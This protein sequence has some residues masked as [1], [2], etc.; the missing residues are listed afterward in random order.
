MVLLTRRL[1]RTA[2]PLAVAALLTT[3]APAI[4]SAAPGPGVGWVR[5]GHLSPKV[6]PVDIYFAPFGQQE[7]VVIR[8]AGYGAVTPYSSLAPGAYTLSMRPA[9]ASPTSP[10]ALT[11][12]ISVSQGTAYSLFVFANGPDGT[13]KE[14]LVTDDMTPPPSGSGRL[15]VVQGAM[16][17]VSATG[18]NGMTFVKDAAY[19][20]TTP[21]SDVPQ[22]RWP[23]RLAV[24]GNT[25]P[26]SVDVRSGSVTT[27]LVTEKPGGGLQTESI[28]DG[29]ALTNAPKL[30]VETGG[31]GTAVPEQDSGVAAWLAL[32]ALALVAGWAAM[33]TRA[34]RAR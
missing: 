26:A 32:G 10:P 29:A 25:Y 33:R 28:A 13:L 2:G 7:K 18:P 1:A 14:D 3:V 9:D 19:G 6:P 11:G 22:G 15:R 27:V 20:L 16:S 17:P 21:Y 8:K 23:L 5:I 34:A 31:G 4:A 30:G 12:T 24:P